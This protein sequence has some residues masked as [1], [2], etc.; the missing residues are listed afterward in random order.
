MS[1]HVTETDSENFENNPAFQLSMN[2][3]SI[4]LLLFV[5]PTWIST[6]TP[7][8]VCPEVSLTSRPSYCKKACT[9]DEQCRKASKRCLCDGLCGLSC[10]NPAATCHPLLDLPN[11]YIRTPGDFV[12]N[13]NAEYGCDEGY[14]LV[15]PSQR[16]C[17]GNHE[18][19]GTNPECRLLMK[20]GPPPEIPYAQHD[21][22]SY[23]GQYDLESE[24]QYSCISGYHRYD[25][26]GI[27]I[28]K[29][30]LNRANAAQWFGPDLRCRAR[31]CP[32]PSQIH[33]GL[34]IGEIFNYPHS[35][36]FSCLPGFQLIGASMLRC[37]S[38]GQWSDDMPHCKAT[39]CPR[40][41]DPLHGKVLGSSL[42]Y[43]SRVTYSCKEG[44]RLVGQ[45]Q[46][47]CLAEGVW[48]GHQ[49]FC[50]EIRC[51]PLP[52]LYNGYIEGSETNF[53]AVVVF[54]CLEAMSHIG[55]P[56]AK[57]E[58][59]A[60][61]SHPMPK[62]LGGCRVPHITNGGIPIYIPGQLVLHGE[63]LKVICAPKHESEADTNIHCH[64]GTW[65]HIPVCLPVRCKLWP[66][67]IP[68]A[69]VV[70]TKSSH[71]ASA[72]YECSVGYKPSS[73]QNTIKCLFGEWLREGEPFRCRP[74]WCEHPSKSFGTLEGGQIMLEGQMGAYE[75]ADYIT[76]VEEGRSI[77]FQCNKGNI[78]LGSPKATCVNGKWMPRRKPKCVSQTH[79]V[80]E[81]HIEW[82]KR[83]KRSKDCDPIVENE[84]YEIVFLNKNNS[85]TETVVVCKPGY[86]MIEATTGGLLTCRDGRWLPGI[87]TCLPEDCYI[88]MKHH[89]YFVDRKT[90]QV[91]SSEVKI[92][93]GNEVQMVCLKGYE[94]TGISA[95]K[96]RFGKLN[97]TL[98]RCRPKRCQVPTSFM[99]SAFPEEKKGLKH[100]E[101]VTIKCNGQSI[102]VSCRFGVLSQSSQ[103]IQGVRSTE[104]SMLCHR[105]SDSHPFIAYRTTVVGGIPT[106]VDLNPFQATFPNNTII[107][108]QCLSNVSE[109][110]A[111]AIQCVN[112]EWIT[113]LLPCAQFN[114][115]I[116]S[117]E[118]FGMC[119]A[120]FID[121]KFKIL[122]MDSYEELNGPRFPHGTIL[123]IGCS[124]LFNN[125]KKK[126][127]ELKC[128]NGRW[129]KRISSLQ[130]PNVTQTCSYHV[131]QRFRTTAFSLS[132]L[133]E[134]TFDQAFSDG[135]TIVFRCS[136]FG[137]QKLRGNPAMT[138]KD[139]RWSSK[140]PRCDILDPLNRNAGPSPIQYNVERAAHFLSPQGELIVNQSADISL[141]CIF[142]R[143]KGQPKW[144]VST[145]YRNYPRSWRRVVLPFLQDVD[146]YELTITTAQ[147]EDGGLFHCVTPND[148]RT[149][150][151]LIIDGK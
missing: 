92:K 65:S 114:S 35:I 19:S 36:E 82:L 28:A 121:S 125:L 38:N 81:G 80:V 139:G 47:T 20:C 57:C 14:V 127:G 70:F 78:L 113:R 144:E 146:A 129:R 112:S 52:P 3:V 102:E 151:K 83:R 74:I 145:T 59:D 130:C 41:S 17:Q 46:R 18:W 110:E 99:R 54:R 150:L 147:P 56:Y 97:D 66:P 32:D 126:V 67:R 45:V 132:D 4:E 40:P 26:K 44:Y 7:S 116:S 9:R 90:S 136:E 55:A 15:G 103:C 119:G 68:N 149:T 118:E 1:A 87:P 141:S 77:L 143:N 91:M 49:P 100:G 88:P 6:F 105:P 48:S 62:C 148:H 72:R 29:C 42:T 140:H 124:S 95:V 122:N 106:R 109:I 50:E 58:E 108:Y 39:T 61:W 79:P 93:H 71:G 16:R 89:S 96:C 75:F 27:T 21:G 101:T 60:R 37:L 128:R 11:G 12:F 138:C 64:N 85:A 86:M 120:P 98:G 69:R 33:N 107:H 111:T 115:T 94:V 23:S 22:Y 104:S 123:K 63:R 131:E 51:S 135:E 117:D 31:S 134:V 73:A 24:V 43:Q 76:E 53:G 84:R 8:N 34:R 137:L 133:Q 30:L 13:S 25:R 2:K 10:V 5:L 142:P